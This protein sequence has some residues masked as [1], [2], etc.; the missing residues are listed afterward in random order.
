[1]DFE[2]PEKNFEDLFKN[3]SF[4][5]SSI[6]ITSFNLYQKQET[7]EEMIA[8]IDEIDKIVEVMTDYPQAKQMLA[9]LYKEK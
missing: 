4:S 9:N 5:F 3:I 8:R 7:A 1:M 2:D 6:P